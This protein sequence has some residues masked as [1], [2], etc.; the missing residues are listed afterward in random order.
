MK[1]EEKKTAEENS[2]PFP[3]RDHPSPFPS[4]P[5]ASEP[6]LDEKISALQKRID[7]ILIEEKRPD[8]GA[9]FELCELKV[10]RSERD[11]KNE[12]TQEN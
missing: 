2:T 5:E 7:K 4:E 11:E 12:P 9:I 8:H 10:L 1:T 6:S 3:P